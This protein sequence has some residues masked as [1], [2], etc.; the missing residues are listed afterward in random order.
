MQHKASASALVPNRAGVGACSLPLVVG[1]AAAEVS[2]VQTL[3][4]G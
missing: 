4:S 2:W 3:L 1:D